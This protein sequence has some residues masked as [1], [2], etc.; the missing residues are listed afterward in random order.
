[1]EKERTLN[2]SNLTKKVIKNLRISYKFQ[3]V[4]KKLIRIKQNKVIR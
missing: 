3:L 2:Q 1:M 4:K